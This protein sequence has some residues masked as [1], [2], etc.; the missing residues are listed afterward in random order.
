MENFIAHVQRGEFSREKNSA[1]I[2]LQRQWAQWR[3]PSDRKLKDI[4]ILFMIPNGIVSGCF[5]PLYFAN[6]V[7]EDLCGE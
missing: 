7:T 4:R 2:R 6:N 5:E 1:Y 3:A